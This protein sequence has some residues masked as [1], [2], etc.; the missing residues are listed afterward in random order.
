VGDVKVDIT[1]LFAVTNYLSE[2]RV[3]ISKFTFMLWMYFVI[4]C[5]SI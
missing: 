3:R 2:T 4:K 5:T 1:K